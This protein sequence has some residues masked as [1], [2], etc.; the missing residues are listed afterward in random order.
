MVDHAYELVSLA[1]GSAQKGKIMIAVSESMAYAFLGAVACMG[2]DILTGYV[3]AV[4]N[5]DVSSTKM[6]EGLGHKALLLCIELLAFVIEIVCQHVEGMDAMSGVTVVGI[7]IVIILM[8]VTSI[9]ENVVS[10][11]PELNNSPLGKI[12]ENT[13]TKEA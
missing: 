1:R 11:S 8:E 3:A 2:I 7:S 10:A 12:F 5:R 9:W 6:R 4:I 13:K